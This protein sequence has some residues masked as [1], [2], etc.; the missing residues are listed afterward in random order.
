MYS[1]LFAVVTLLCV[2]G[3]LAA[4][5]ALNTGVT[6]TVT[7]PAATTLAQAD[8]AAIV[9]KIHDSTGTPLANLNSMK[10]DATKLTV[11]AD[12]VTSVKVGSDTG[13]CTNLTAAAEVATNAAG[14]ILLKD[15]S[16][17]NGKTCI[18]VTLTK[19]GTLKNTA[20]Q[21]DA[22]VVTASTDGTAAADSSDFDA[23]KAVKAAASATAVPC[24]P[25]SADSPAKTAK[26]DEGKTCMC[27]AAADG[28]LCES[29]KDALHT[30]EKKDSAFECTKDA[31][32]TTKKSGAHHPA[33]AATVLLLIGSYRFVM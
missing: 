32:S 3:T 8:T 1:S 19:V 15:A 22:V 29:K 11:S 4:N 33:I 9:I 18:E 14:V 13:A 26:V 17:L 27:G 25:C 2:G 5:V 12:I 31:K 23:T 7:L 20:C 16:K 21:T 28:K 6:A 10:I 24:K 30:C